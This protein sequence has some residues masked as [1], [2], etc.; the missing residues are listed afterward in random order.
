MDGVY[1]AHGNIRNEYKILM[2][3]VNIGDYLGDDSIMKDGERTTHEGVYRIR[4]VVSYVQWRFIW[5]KYLILT[6]LLRI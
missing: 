3:S 5:R 2:K 6:K 1:S 4:V